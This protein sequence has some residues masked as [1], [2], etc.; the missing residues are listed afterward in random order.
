MLVRVLELSCCPA[1][2]LAHDTLQ[3]CVL[4]SSSCCVLLLMAGPSLQHCLSSAFVSALWEI[5]SPQM[6]KASCQSI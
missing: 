4:R 5:S 3:V 1:S 2:V 6:L